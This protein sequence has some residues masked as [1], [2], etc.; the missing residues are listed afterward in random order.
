MGE[1]Q[2]PSGIGSES[3]RFN[4]FGGLAPEQRKRVAS[5]CSAWVASG[6]GPELHIVPGFVAPMVQPDPMLTI[7]QFAYEGCGARRIGE[8]ITFLARV[9]GGYGPPRS[10]PC[11]DIR[12][13]RNRHRP[14]FRP[15]Q[16]AQHAGKGILLSPRTQVKPRLL[17][18]PVE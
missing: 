16:E 12:A 6:T 14:G 11:L 5:E 10:L 7:Y 2:G 15:V 4:L 13:P 8:R 1:T 17:L 9:L 3:F 18:A